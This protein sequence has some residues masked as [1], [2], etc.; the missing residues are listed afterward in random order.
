MTC[1]DLESPPMVDTCSWYRT[2]FWGIRVFKS[3]NAIA[4]QHLLRVYH[5]VPIVE[6]FDFSLPS[7]PLPSLPLASLPLASLPFLHMKLP[8]HDMVVRICHTSGM[9]FNNMTNTTS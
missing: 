8:A 3:I 2:A 5:A 6:N 7:L 4:S 9:H 1:R